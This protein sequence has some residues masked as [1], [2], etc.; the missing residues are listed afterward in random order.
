MRENL[1]EKYKR[2]RFGSAAI[3]GLV[4]VLVI[5]ACMLWMSEEPGLH[6]FFLAMALLF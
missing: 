5:G 6:N 4:I 2:N 3:I 1:S